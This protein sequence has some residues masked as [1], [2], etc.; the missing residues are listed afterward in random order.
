MY[1]YMYI[2]R[3][4]YIYTY[5]YVSAYLYILVLFGREQQ[6]CVFCLWTLAEP[7]DLG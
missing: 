3:Y 4:I 2:Y 5:I 6:L 1:I 7:L